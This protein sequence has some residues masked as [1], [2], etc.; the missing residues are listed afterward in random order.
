MANSRCIEVAIKIYVGLGE[1]EGES[2]D[3]GQSKKGSKAKLV[4]QYLRK[5]RCGEGLCADE[6]CLKKRINIER[7]DRKT[8]TYM[9]E[10]IVLV[11]NNSVQ[12]SL[13]W[14]PG[15]EKDCADESCLKKKDE[16]EERDRK[17]K[18]LT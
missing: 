11:C 17:S 16:I 9:K 13:Q 4:A 5:D 14:E 8:R 2:K 3:T 1:E 15:V 10:I 12:F 18:E 7:R 6:G